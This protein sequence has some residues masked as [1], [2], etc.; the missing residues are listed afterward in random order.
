MANQVGARL[1]GDDY[2]HLYSWQ[3]VLKLKMPRKKVRLVTIEDALAGS[4]DDVTVQHEP[5]THEPDTF[6]Q[7]KFHVDQRS[8]YSTEA[9]IAHKPGQASLL[10]KFWRTWNML[11]KQDPGRD[12]V[13]HLVTNWTWDAQDKLRSC[14]SGQNNSMKEDFFTAKPQSDIGK[15]RRKLQDA[16]G[17]TDD[18]FAAFMRCMRFRLGF[19]CRDELEKRIAERMENLHLKYD[20]SALLIAAGIVRNW[21]QSG[22]QEIRLADLEATLKAHDLYLPDNVEKCS[23]VYLVTIKTQKF[24]M[25]PDHILDWRDYFIGDPNKKGHQLENPTAW[26]SRL[27][28]EL[29]AL[30]AQINK[31]T[32]CRLV[33]ARGLDRLSAWFA[34]GFTFSDVARYTIEVDQHGQLWRTDAHPNPDFRLIFTGNNSSPDGEILDGEGSTVAVGISVT[35]SLEDDMRTFLSTREEKIASLL[36]MQ[37]ERGYGRECLRNASDVVA[38]ADGVKDSLRAFVK[39]WN[40]TRLLLFYFGPLSGACFIGHRLNAVCRE[41]QIMEDQQPGYAPSFLL[42]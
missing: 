17:A 30:E 41:I 33:R 2:Q 39:K 5:G 42:R 15:L 27:L 20:G 1:S 13:L 4:V 18:D 10:E 38:L 24:D 40:A 11:R 26:N 8:S 9:L 19:D 29:Q 35:G 34:F 6:Y 12:I 22:R 23:T 25:E 21:I 14:L 3:F 28:P 7:V 36:L 31:E 16:I 32:S 37:P